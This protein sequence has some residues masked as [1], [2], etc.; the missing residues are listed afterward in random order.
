[1]NS[2]L[3][4]WVLHSDLLRKFLEAELQ[5]GPCFVAR[6]FQSCFILGSLAAA[7]SENSQLT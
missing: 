5:T 7:S 2:N 1:M 3:Q 6:C 4:L